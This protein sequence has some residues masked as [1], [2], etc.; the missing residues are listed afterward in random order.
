[1]K[2]QICGK[3]NATIHI[4]EI[5]NGE[6]HSYY[7]CEECAAKSG[8]SFDLAQIV[9]NITQTLSQ[10][11][12]KKTEEKL[13][14]EE[15]DNMEKVLSADSG[16]P[17]DL[18]R[19]PGCNWSMEQV[20]KVGVLGCP[21]CYN[22]FR[23]ALVKVLKNV[24]RGLEHKGTSPAGT[25]RKVSGD[26]RRK[27]ELALLQEEALLQKELQIAVAREEYEQAALLRDRINALKGLKNAGECSHGK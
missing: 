1:M 11:E 6:K 22:A 21:E 24:H 17:K 23:N 13:P 15:K 2:C 3:D 8:K 20:R 27:K 4:R 9:Q 14:P 18:A 5:R 16:A 25:S 10:L 26:S 7:I 19:C 12:N